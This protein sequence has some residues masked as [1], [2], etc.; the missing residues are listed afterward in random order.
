MLFKAWTTPSKEATFIEEPGCSATPNYAHE[1]TSAVTL[2]GTSITVAYNGI[3]FKAI[4]YASLVENGAGGSATAGTG[5]GGA[6]GTG[7][8]GSPGAGGATTSGTASA[9]GSDTGHAGTG[10][11]ELGHPG[12]SSGCQI[13][14]EAAPPPATGLALLA[15]LLLARRPRRRKLA[16]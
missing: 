13:A 16:T 6:G 12:A 15:G 7:T 9:G 10:G 5:T 4:R 8:G 3:T 14:M 11:S 1:F 2:N